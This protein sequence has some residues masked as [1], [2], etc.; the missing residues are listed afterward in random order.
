MEIEN[1]SNLGDHMK[2]ERF[3][4]IPKDIKDTEKVSHVGVPKNGWLI[5]Y[6]LKYNNMA[7]VKSR[8]NVL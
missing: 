4:S 6:C 8:E 3:H 5:F 7:A 1:I 2:I